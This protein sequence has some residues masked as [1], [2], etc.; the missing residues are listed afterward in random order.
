MIQVP[1]T[2]LAQVDSSVGGKTAVN[3]PLGKTPSVPSSNRIMSHRSRVPENPPSRELQAGYFE[4]AKH[5]LTHD[6]ELLDFLQEGKLEPLD[7][8][9]LEEAVFR[10]C[11]VK[12]RIVE[13]D[14]TEAGSEQP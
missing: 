14:E 3:H 10:S 5:G 8:D 7:L 11:R 9:F 13:Q 4:L 1:T 12:A 2:L 6:R